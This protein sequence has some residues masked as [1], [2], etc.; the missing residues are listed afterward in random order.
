VNDSAGCDNRACRIGLADQTDNTKG[1]E[2]RGRNA[3][4]GQVIISRTMQI[5][6]TLPDVQ[7]ADKFAD[8]VNQHGRVAS[9]VSADRAVLIE[10]PDKSVYDGCVKIA[11]KE[12]WPIQSA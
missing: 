11:E 10:T 1:C 7:T 2:M 6:L 5:V 3:F 9:A 12:G 4:A 8:Y